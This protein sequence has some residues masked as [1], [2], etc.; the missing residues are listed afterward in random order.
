MK[1]ATMLLIL[2]LCGAAARGAAGDQAPVVT[3]GEGKITV[4]NARL[5]ALISEANGA[6]VELRSAGRAR[7]G[8]VAAG[9]NIYADIG[10]LSPGSHP[11]YGTKAVTNARVTVT[12][13]A[14]RV[15]VSSEGEPALDDGKSPPEAR[16]SYRLRYTFDDTSTVEM[17]AGVRTDSPRPAGRSG[18]LAATFDIG[19]VDEWFADTR[20]GTRW[21]D[22]G[23]GP[24][25][26]FEAHQ[27]PLLRSRPRLGLLSRTIGAS[28]S[29]VFD[30]I[31][32]SPEGALN[33][34]ILY[35]GGGRRATLF[36]NWIES[37]ASIAF[38]AGHW[39]D[40]TCRL[41]IA[42][43]IPGREP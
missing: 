9:A 4:S 11:Y 18:F 37:E 16:W 5:T 8:P 41:T 25:R 43:G 38:E 39:Y 10:V 2:L 3:R 17:L 21:V 12:A 23:A 13:E 34:V 28:G 24:G 36:L 14:G 27:T 30:R 15:I 6:L 40:I 19:G 22:L 35:D 20:D 32:G 33:D 42:D 31:S 29:I 26:C 7:T 1:A